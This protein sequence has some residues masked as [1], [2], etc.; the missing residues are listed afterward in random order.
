MAYRF[1]VNEQ[2]C[3]N[4]GICMDLCPVRCLDMTRPT[5]EGTLASEAERQSPIPVDFSTRGWMMLTPVQVAACIGCQVCAQECPTNAITIE[6]GIPAVSYAQRGPVSHLP[7]EQGWQPLDAYTRASPEEPGETPWGDRSRL[8]CRRAR[9][10]PGRAGAPGWASAKKIS[11]RRAR[12]HVR[13]AP[14]PDSTSA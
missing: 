11:E 3:I 9:G 10:T 2:T 14:T 1:Q 6:S 5:S 7:A 4:C 8:A 12:R 13:S